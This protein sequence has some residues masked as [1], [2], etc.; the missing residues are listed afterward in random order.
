MMVDFSLLEQVQADKKSLTV[1]R[2]TQFEVHYENA[3]DA[4]Y[5]FEEE[6]DKAFLKEA[7]SE[8]LTALSYQ[9]NRVEPYAYLAYAMFAV[10]SPKLGFAYLNLA[11]TLDPDF[12]LIDQICQALQN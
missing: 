8:L 7:V 5:D 10:Q 3:L 6:C 9:R 2:Q 4:L 11:K 1:Q 12:F